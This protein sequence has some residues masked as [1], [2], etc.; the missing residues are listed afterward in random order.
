MNKIR[1][2]QNG[3]SLLEVLISMIILGVGILG[4]APMIVLSIEGNNISQD[5]LSVSTIAKDRLERYEGATAFPAVP[6]TNVEYNIDGTYDVT[7]TLLDNASDST[8]PLGNYQVNIY[9]TWTDKSGVPR[10]TTYTTLVND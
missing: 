6:Y 7:T 9:I 5:V 10:N 2:N 4:L 3:L 8:I 1:N